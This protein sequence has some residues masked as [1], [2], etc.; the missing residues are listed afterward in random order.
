MSHLNTHTTT[1]LTGHGTHENTTWCPCICQVTSR[2]TAES[3]IKINNCKSKFVESRWE[4]L[5]FKFIDLGK[6][7]IK[8]GRLDSFLQITATNF[9]SSSWLQTTNVQCFIFLKAFYN[10][11]C[12]MPIYK[13]ILFCNFGIFRVLDSIN[14]ALISANCKRVLLQL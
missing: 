7:F 1:I 2:R 4:S 10:F 12:Y 5:N 14:D 3:A 6:M 8:H 11:F 13:L 9:F